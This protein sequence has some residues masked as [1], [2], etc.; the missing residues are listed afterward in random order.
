[1]CAISLVK[2]FYKHFALKK[3]SLHRLCWITTTSWHNENPSRRWL[4]QRLWKFCHIHK[5]R[6]CIPCGIHYVINIHLK[7]FILKTISINIFVLSHFTLALEDESKRPVERFG[8]KFIIRVAESLFIRIVT[9]MRKVPYH[10]VKPHSEWFKVSRWLY[11]QKFGNA[12]D[13]HVFFGCIFT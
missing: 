8:A 3:R 9:T 11:T 12:V 5:H 10:L 7:S 2:F 6:R 1:M 13:D 4:W